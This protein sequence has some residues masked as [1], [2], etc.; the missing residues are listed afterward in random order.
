MDIE[1][2]RD[3]PREVIRRWTR[4]CNLCGCQQGTLFTTKEKKAGETS[5]TISEIEVPK[6]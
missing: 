5:G 3:V 4:K 1:S 6:F 2:E